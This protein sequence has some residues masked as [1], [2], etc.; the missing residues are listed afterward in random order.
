VNKAK[1]GA[2]FVM[3]APSGGGKTSLSRELI[4]QSSYLEGSVSVTTRP[5]RPGEKDSV[6]YYFVTLERF[7][8]LKKSGG[9]LESVRLFDNWYGTPL[10]HL[11]EKVAD[12]IDV[13][14]T[15][16]WNGLCQ[17]KQ[18][19]PGQVVSIFLLPPSFSEI[20]KRLVQRNQDA[21]EVVE[22]RMSEFYLEISRWKAYDY[23]V[24][25]ENFTEALSDLQH[26]ICAQRLRR[27]YCSEFVS[28]LVEQL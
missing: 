20:R 15:L 23:I 6:D 25:N 28:S 11:Q 2:I 14:C 21:M 22:K 16:D 5:P 18:V 9:L 10:K 13:V 7:E 24:V 26:I 27:S 12:G 3:S 8:Q 19:M 1:N 4:A 17:L